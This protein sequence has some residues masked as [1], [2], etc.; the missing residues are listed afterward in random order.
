VGLYRDLPMW[1]EIAE[2]PPYGRAM[3]G[4]IR[5]LWLAPEKSVTAISTEQLDWAVAQIEQHAGARWL[6]A[7]H[8][9][10]RLPIQRGRKHC[11]DG[12]GRLYEA[13]ARHAT[14]TVFAG[15]HL[16]LSHAAPTREGNCITMVSGAMNVIGGNAH[17]Y[18]RRVTFG[19]SDMVRVE[20][21]HLD[22]L[23]IEESWEFSLS[24]GAPR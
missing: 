4:G 11:L 14:S 3:V 2:N 21:I 16:H 19:P 6:I 7:S 12:S 17:S 18:G 1:D 13:A 20:V 15:A 5:V 8:A 9:P 22:A 23:A 24:R 10:V